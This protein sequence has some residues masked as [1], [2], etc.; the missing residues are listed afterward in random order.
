MQDGDTEK[1]T[2]PVRE[3]HKTLSESAFVD[4]L[5]VPVG[6]EGGGVSRSVKVSTL[7]KA[8]ERPGRAGTQLVISPGC[9]SSLRLGKGSRKIVKQ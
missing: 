1:F 5:T 6:G 4:G 3:K 9:R 8:A 2:V 7:K